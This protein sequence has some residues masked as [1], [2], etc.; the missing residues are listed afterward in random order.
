MYSHQNHLRFH[1]HRMRVRFPDLLH[2]RFPD[3]FGHFRFPEF[4]PFRFPEFRPF[5]FPEF[6]QL[7][8]PFPVLLF[9]VLFPVYPRSIF[10]SSKQYREKDKRHTGEVIFF[11]EKSNKL[12][13]IQTYP[14]HQYTMFFVQVNYFQKV[15]FVYHFIEEFERKFFMTILLY[16]IIRQ[17]FEIKFRIKYNFSRLL[18]CNKEAR[19]TI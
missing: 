13:V 15:L 8:F 18:T 10:F 14:N 7:R 5:R 19:T 9:P 17:I 12:Q 1:Q 4:R 2:F 3:F 6:R 11:R 16:K